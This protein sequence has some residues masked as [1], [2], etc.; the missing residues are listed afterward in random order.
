MSCRT[1]RA[2]SDLDYISKLVT[3]TSRGT[4][5]STMP[6]T[7]MSGIE[8]YMTP[9]QTSVNSDLYSSC[10]DMASVTAA[11]I[12]AA[13]AV[14][15]QFFTS[16]IRDYYH[17]SVLAPCQPYMSAS[18]TIPCAIPYPPSQH[19]SPAMTAQAYSYSSAELGA[20]LQEIA[21]SASN[22]PMPHI[23]ITSPELFNIGGSVGQLGAATNENE[24][25]SHIVGQAHSFTPRMGS[26]H[27]S[28]N[29]S[30]LHSMPITGPMSGPNE[31]LF[32]GN[33]ECS[34]AAH[35]AAYVSNSKVGYVGA[36]HTGEH[37]LD[38]ASL[39]HSFTSDFNPVSLDSS[40]SG[41]QITSS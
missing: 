8:V 33:R 40:C 19:Y 11:S 3:A 28:A 25:L 15:G 29:E 36:Y 31:P 21:M 26:S 38:T 4:T 1:D 12:G 35:A 41:L 16:G 7:P 22:S 18:G 23:H 17:E 20:R 6:A 30:F 39:S 34:G 27:C 10:V 13:S 24:L 5:Q 32:G 14:S 37:T 2:D 9:H